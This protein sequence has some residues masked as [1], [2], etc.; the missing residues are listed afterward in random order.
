[1]GG[2]KAWGEWNAAKAR[3]MQRTGTYEW[4]LPLTRSDFE[5]GEHYKYVLIDT[6]NPDHVLWED[7]DDRNLRVGWV[8]GNA[9]L[10]RQD[11][12]PHLSLPRGRAPAA[13]S[14][15]SRCAARAVLAWATS[16][17]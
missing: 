4:C 10:V 6:M 13:S 15:C 7:G 14:P 3:P 5:Q 12:R 2:S 1:M 8:P 17:I 16:A 11:E 9:C